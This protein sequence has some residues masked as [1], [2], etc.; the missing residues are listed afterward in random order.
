MRAP[1]ES[2]TRG[3][4]GPRVVNHLRLASTAGRLLAKAVAAVDRLVAAWHERHFGLLTAT[5]TSSGMHFTLA[6]AAATGALRRSTGRTT[7]R[8][9]RVAFFGVVRLVFG[10]E[11]KRSPAVLAREL[12][13][14]V[15]HPWSPFLR[16]G[17]G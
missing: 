4:I 9:V 7:L 13:V 17:K 3:L 10:V 12:L 11:R 6:S 16:I 5:S 8:L 1:T 14:G 2:S 15:A